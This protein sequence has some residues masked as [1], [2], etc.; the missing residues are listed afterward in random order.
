MSQSTRVSPP[1]SIVF[2]S[3]PNGGVAP[4][5]VRGALILS[6]PS[7]VSVGCK[8]EQ[9]G[10]TMFVLGRA[11]EVDPGGR[12]AFDGLLETPNQAIVVSTVERESLLADNVLTKRTRV[13][14]W[15]NHPTEPDK[16]IVGVG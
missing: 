8:M 3:D 9:D 12:P 14:V 16:V 5:P 1:N 2:I 13:R 15:V 11:P 10:P 4:R 7:C 6:S